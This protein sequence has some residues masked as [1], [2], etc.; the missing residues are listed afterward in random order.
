MIDTIKISTEKFKIGDYDLFVLD[1]TNKS[2]KG[3]MEMLKLYPNVMYSIKAHL[4]EINDGKYR[5]RIE[6]V[7][8]LY[9][10][11]TIYIEFSIPKLLF[12]QNLSEVT[13][14]ND[15]NVVNKLITILKDLNITVTED[16]INN[17]FV[18]RVDFSKNYELKD[19]LT[20]K[21][22]L[23]LLSKVSYPRMKL[24]V[25]KEEEYIKFYNKSMALLFYDKQKE[26]KKHNSKL[27]TNYEQD[28][29]ILR[30]EIQI[31]GK[32]IL[33]KL[34][35]H[36]TFK[37]IFSEQLFKHVFYKY[38]MKLNKCIPDTFTNEKEL[39][40]LYKGKTN[41]LSNKMVIFSA[42]EKYD[43][44]NEAIQHLTKIYPKYFLKRYNCILIKKEG[45]K[46][47]LLKFLEEIKDYTPLFNS[48]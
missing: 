38:L 28:I 9:R 14:K 46:F 3:L 27:P 24:H 26:L 32:N 18:K 8:P 16:A 20:C 1:K 12:G 41:E 10:N 25:I 36:N 37:E 11:P 22:V 39:T 30:I 17:A 19:D 2:L 5:P 34:T 7:Y 13:E 42:Q 48:S 21:D 29:P 45:L 33:D 15:I 23:S 43:N 47:I 6:Y 31:K 40:D 4:K 44:Y 35:E